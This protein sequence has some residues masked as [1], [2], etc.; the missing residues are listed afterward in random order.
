MMKKF[1][2]VLLGL[3]VSA[4]VCIAA[5]DKTDVTAQYISNA[6]FESDDITTLTPKTETADG[7]RGYIVTAPSGWTVS[8]SVG[9]VSLIVTADCFTDNN[10]GKVTTLADGSQAYYQRVGWTNGSSSVKQTIA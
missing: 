7:L 9:A 5:D 10:F 4:S 6:S 8:N 3:I 1:C 2:I